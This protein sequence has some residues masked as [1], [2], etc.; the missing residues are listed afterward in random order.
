MQKY[1][2]WYGLQLKAWCKNTVNWCQ[3]LALVSFLL[4]VFSI[5]LPSTDSTV[6]GLCRYEEEYAE[7]IC[8]ILGE[9]NDMIIL[10]KY[11]AIEE[12][13]NDILA[14]KIECGFVFAEDFTKCLESRNIENSI[15]VMERPGM[16]VGHVVREEFFA[17]YF[18]VYAEEILKIAAEEIFVESDM[19]LEKLLNR[20]RQY[21]KSDEVFQ[22]EQ[23]TVKN[24]IT[25]PL[26]RDEI[27]P[28]QGMI[29]ILFFLS[30]MLRIGE[31]FSQRKMV[32]QKALTKR[33]SR[34]FDAL[35]YAAQ[36]TLPVL[37]ALC[38]IEISG[39]SR[40]FFYEMSKMLVFLIYCYIWVWF[41]CRY[42]NSAAAH[43]TWSL[44][45]TIA[46]GIIHPVFIDMTKYFWGLRYIKYL[47]PL[48]IYI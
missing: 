38:V 11:D 8:N 14:G 23:I 40:G 27:Y 37:L 28:V 42:I 19:V 5:Q 1:I 18:Q 43:M 39:V 7:K 36:N 48:G 22:I 2:M 26:Q 12:M 46:Q 35:G 29:G 45:F 31:K 21:I 47:F 20:Y 32:V 34:I 25:D 41:V 17:A 24:R 9:S 3:L 6:V 16:T 4:I 30:A 44:A 10:R 13:S 15:T 33:E